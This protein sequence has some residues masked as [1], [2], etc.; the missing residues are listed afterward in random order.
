MSSMLHVA[1]PGSFFFLQ[2]R[3]SHAFGSTQ[4]LDSV[5]LEFT[6]KDFKLSARFGTLREIIQFDNRQQTHLLRT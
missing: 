3:V 1:D 2:K 5:I 6:R 4:N